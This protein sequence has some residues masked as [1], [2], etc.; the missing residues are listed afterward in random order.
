MPGSSDPIAGAIEV[1]RSR[2]WNVPPVGA[3]DAGPVSGQA[4]GSSVKS[5][6]VSCRACLIT[7]FRQWAIKP[8]VIKPKPIRAGSVQAEPVQP[9]SVE[10]RPVKP[11]VIKPEPVR[12]RPVESERVSAGPICARSLVIQPIRLESVTVRPIHAWPV[13]PQPVSR[14]SIPARRVKPQP[15]NLGPIPGL[16]EPIRPAPAEATRIESAAFPSVATCLMLLAARAGAVSANGVRPPV[17]VS[18]LTV[19]VM[20]WQAVGTAN[21]LLVVNRLG[22]DLA[23]LRLAAAVSGSL[24]SLP[25]PTEI[26]GTGSV[27]GIAVVSAATARRAAAPAALPGTVVVGIAGLADALRPPLT[28]VV[29]PA[30]AVLIRQMVLS[31]AGALT[32]SG[33]IRPRPVRMTGKRHRPVRSRRGVAIRRRQRGRSDRT[34]LAEPLLGSRFGPVVQL[35]VRFALPVDRDLDSDAYGDHDSDY[36]DHDDR[37]HF[38]SPAIWPDRSVAAPEVSLAG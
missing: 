2:V 16:A 22:T 5:E 15:V 38:W 30:A 13:K 14:R 23:V 10:H 1:S 9:G 26:F 35:A 36:Q 33:L 18:S 28:A 4:V 11:R 17:A 34:E 32:L 12:T 31:S 27:A 8:G 20:V 21:G 24:L 29:R 19:I 6:P 25:P 3:V 37:S 7:R